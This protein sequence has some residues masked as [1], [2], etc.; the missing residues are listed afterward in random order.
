MGHDF[1]TW[2]DFIIWV[3]CAVVIYLCLN[4]RVYMIFHHPG[5]KLRAKVRRKPT[6]KP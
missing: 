2:S 4:F 5:P 1:P 6:S 3:L